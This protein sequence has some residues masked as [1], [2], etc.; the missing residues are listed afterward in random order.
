MKRAFV[1]IGIIVMV[2]VIGLA[3]PYSPMLVEIITVQE[4]PIDNIVKEGDVIF[5]TTQTT[6]S[7]LI[8]IGTRS[9]V[10]HCGII[11]MRDGK[12]YVLET[13][14]TLVVTPIEDFIA[15]GKGG[16]Y[17]LKRSQLEDIKIEYDEYLDKPYDMQFSLCNDTYYCSELVYDIYLKQLNINLC[18]PKRID[19]YLILGTER[20]PQI[21]ETM[22]ER[23]I[24]MDQYAVAP[25]DIFNSEKLQ[26]VK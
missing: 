12:P 9:R 18:E 26:L 13:L 4:H 24:T 14:G 25:V 17:W 11:V 22:K 21:K 23:G 7:K 15:R 1:Y 19:D 3:L 8:Q 5:Q 2:V 6:Q 20:I 16:K 10:T